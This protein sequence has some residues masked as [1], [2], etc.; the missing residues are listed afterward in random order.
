M[1]N[2]FFVIPFFLISTKFECINEDFT[3]VDPEL[4]EGDY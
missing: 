3:N 2:R 1:Q 4:V